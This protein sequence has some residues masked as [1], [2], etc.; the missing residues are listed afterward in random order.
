MS[1][2]VSRVLEKLFIKKGKQ[3]DIYIRNERLRH[4]YLKFVK[5]TN[6][7]KARRR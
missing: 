5:N 2:S 6:T 4:I 1:E 7:H 3:N